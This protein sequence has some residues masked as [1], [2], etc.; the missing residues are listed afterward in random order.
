[1]VGDVFQWKKSSHKGSSIGI[2]FKLSLIGDTTARNVDQR[3]D[4]TQQLLHPFILNDLEKMVT[5]YNN[6]FT[7][8]IDPVTG[9]TTSVSIKHRDNMRDLADKLNDRATNKLLNKYIDDEQ[10][11]ANAERLTL[12][13]KLCELY[14]KLNSVSGST[15]C[16]FAQ[17]VIA[18]TLSDN[19]VAIT[20][21]LTQLRHDA[22]TRETEA[23]QVSFQ[24]EMAANIEADAKDYEKYLQ[25]F[26]LLKGSWNKIDYDDKTNENID[27]NIRDFTTT[28]QWNRT[29]GT[30]AD[31]ADQYNGDISAIDA[32][33]GIF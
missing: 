6:H 12:E 11:I 22:I 18:H 33:G 32:A 2:G 8:T 27:H 1:M 19:N 26:S 15:R 13:H 30:I 23:M 5:C 9:L 20:G 24:A 29:A 10:K 28:G 31:A 4:Y 7:C 17:S 3:R 16:S 21:M 14:P 25:A